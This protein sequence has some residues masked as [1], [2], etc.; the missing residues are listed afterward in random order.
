MQIKNCLSVM[1][2]GALYYCFSCA[3]PR[4]FGVCNR[5]LANFVVILCCTSSLCHATRSL[6]LVNHL[7]HHLVDIRAC[8]TSWVSGY[9]VSFSS[10][11][12]FH[13]LLSLP[14]CFTCLVDPPKISR[15]L[16]RRFASVG[17]WVNSCQVREQNDCC[18]NSEQDVL[19]WIPL[20][21]IAKFH[22]Y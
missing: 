13:F 21:A 7:P 8:T 5:N 9:L 16:G 1:N 4:M 22:I 15:S 20:P 10:P 14:P 12:P 11:P 2:T 6:N 18:C 17:Y 3:L 19:S